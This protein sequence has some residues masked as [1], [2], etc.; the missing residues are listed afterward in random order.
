MSLKFEFPQN[1]ELTITGCPI[2]NNTT[3]CLFYNPPYWRVSV[4]NEKYVC[5]NSDIY[6]SLYNFMD[7]SSTINSYEL[8]ELFI[9]M[10]GFVPV[11]EYISNRSAKYIGIEFKSMD[12]FLSLTKLNEYTTLLGVRIYKAYVNNMPTV[13]GICKDLDIDETKIVLEHFPDFVEKYIINALN[14]LMCNEKFTVEDLSVYDY[15]GILSILYSVPKFIYGSE[16]YDHTPLNL[17]KTG[18]VNRSVNKIGHRNI[19]DTNYDDTLLTENIIEIC[20]Y[21]EELAK[22]QQLTKLEAACMKL[23]LKR[24]GY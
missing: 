13:L 4:N 24:W 22:R 17:I 21:Y 8:V 10:L 9:E 20:P 1:R 2:S 6:A 15:L 11:Y 7:Y 19:M 16:I 12:D 5:I 14:V 18:N 23:F 3:I